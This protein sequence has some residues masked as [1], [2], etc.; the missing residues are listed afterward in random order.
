MEEAAVR[1]LTDDEI[2]DDEIAEEWV[3]E[4]VVASKPKPGPPALGAGFGPLLLGVFHRYAALSR[5]A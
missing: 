4:R 5:S 3:R 1:R 2:M